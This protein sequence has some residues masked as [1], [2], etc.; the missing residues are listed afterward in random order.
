MVI[1]RQL[2]SVQVMIDQKQLGNV[3][4]F[5]CWGNIITNG[6]KFT[7]E[8]KSRIAM[9][10]A[11]FRKRKD[12]FTSKLD[13]NLRKKLVKCYIRSIALYGAETWILREVDQ[14]YIASFEMWCWRRMEIGWTDSMRNEVLNGVKEERNVIYTIKSGKLSG[15]ATYC[16]GTAF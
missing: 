6:T 7:W 8:I 5:D 16:L 14:I 2:S 15:L 11:A 10:K 3:E 12:L 4:Y 13:L 1:S 9:V